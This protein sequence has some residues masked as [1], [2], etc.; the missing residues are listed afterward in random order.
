[1]V[2]RLRLPELRG[3]DL[4]GV[5]MIIGISTYFAVLLWPSWATVA[6]WN[7]WNLVILAT[8]DRSPAGGP[9]TVASSSALA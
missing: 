2:S 3:N 4:V 6:L 7:G 1:M 9:E 8:A 5:L